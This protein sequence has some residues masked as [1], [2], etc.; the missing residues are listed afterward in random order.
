MWGF[1]KKEEI[2]TQIVHD[3]YYVGECPLC[4]I[5]IKGYVHGYDKHEFEDK[6]IQECYKCTLAIYV[7]KITICSTIKK[8]RKISEN[9]SGLELISEEELK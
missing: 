8:Y 3:A 9:F 5:P 6:L 4:K 7:K 1:K 2:L